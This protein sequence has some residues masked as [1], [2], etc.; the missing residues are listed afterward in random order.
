MISRTWCQDDEDYNYR[1]LEP[2]K[3]ERT[4]G[5]G[6]HRAEFRRVAEESETRELCS[7]WGN[8]G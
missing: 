8:E 1:G 4:R 3:G 5:K 7:P 6:V 2:I